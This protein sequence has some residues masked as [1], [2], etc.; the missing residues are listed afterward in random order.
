MLGPAPSQ[1]E[2]RDL[3]RVRESERIRAGR[4]LLQVRLPC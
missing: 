3:E 1:K 2:E 4:E